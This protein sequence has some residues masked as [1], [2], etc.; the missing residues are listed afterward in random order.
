MVLTFNLWDSE[1]GMEWLDSGKHGMC[2]TDERASYINK[3]FKSAYVSWSKIKV[4]EIGSTTV[5]YETS[6]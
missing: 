2:N 5:G 6:G 4:G 3:N 1:N